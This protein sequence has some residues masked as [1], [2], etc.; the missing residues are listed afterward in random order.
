LGDSARDCPAGNVP[1]FFHNSGSGSLGTPAT[2]ALSDGPTST[3]ITDLD[4][5][6]DGRPDLVVVDATNDFVKVLRNRGSRSFAPY[7]EYPIG[8][9]ASDVATADFDGDGRFDIATSNRNSATASVL[10]SRCW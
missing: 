8:A 5:D 7:G 10:M 9:G 2:L 6:G 3:Q 1:Y 4:G